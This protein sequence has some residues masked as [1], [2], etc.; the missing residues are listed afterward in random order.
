MKL[1][2]QKYFQLLEDNFIYRDHK[3]EIDRVIKEELEKEEK[4]REEES[5]DGT[6]SQLEQGQLLTAIR[7]EEYWSCPKEIEIPD[8]EYEE[9][10][11]HSELLNKYNGGGDKLAFAFESYQ[12][13]YEKEQQK[14]YKL[15][16]I[17]ERLM[18]EGVND[19]DDKIQVL[20]D[21]VLE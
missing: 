10:K 6:L 9:L 16:K 20:L 4:R 3:D 1:E 21:I 18:D 17:I 7:S 13:K 14:N 2:K 12:G 8:S 11:Q 5:S 19:M 15:Q